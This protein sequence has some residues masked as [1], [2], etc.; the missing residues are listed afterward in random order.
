MGAANMRLLR[1]QAIGLTV[2]LML[3]GIIVLAVT[4]YPMVCTADDEQEDPPASGTE[5]ETD[6]DQGSGEGNATEDGDDAPEEGDGEV[7]PAEGDPTEGDVPEGV[8]RRRPRTAEQERIY[9]Q[10]KS[11]E[12]PFLNQLP[13]DPAFAGESIYN[14]ADWLDT[15]VPRDISRYI[16]QDETGRIV[17]YETVAVVL[18]SSMVLGDFIHLSRRWEGNRD[19]DVNLWLFAD[20]F[21]PRRK[22][23]REQ[24]ESRTGSTGSPPAQPDANDVQELY[25]GMDEVTVDYFFDRITVTHQSGD[26]SAMHTMR[27]LP[28]S[29]DIDSL[30]L[31]ARLLKFARGDWPFEAAISNPERESN[32][33][34][35]IGAPVRVDGVYS[36]EGV[37][38]KCYELRLVIAGEE[39]QY[40]VERLPPH[41]LVKFTDA[42]YTYTLLEYME[43]Q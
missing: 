11:R 4:V 18:E 13:V 20:T 34:V 16:V 41:R 31:L 30:P 22:T 21:K 12:D 37:A 38:Y 33:A 32:L 8:R 9:K 27:Q 15:Q 5:D 42:A 43:Q 7:V 17:G 14:P 35:A 6:D 23:T 10:R 2:L 36:A 40:W 1:H 28:F 24:D 39:Y 19:A 26:V 25:S 3:A 29:Y